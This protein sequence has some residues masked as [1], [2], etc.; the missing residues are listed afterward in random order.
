MDSILSWIGGKRL[1]RKQIIPMIPGD[2]IAYIEP[3]GGA[4]WILFAKERHAQVEV[5]NDLDGELVNLFMIIKYH[6]DALVQELAYLI[7][8]RALFVKVKNNPGFT[9]IQRAVRFLY[10]IK[11]SFGAKGAHYGTSKVSGGAGLAS[12]ANIIT[13]AEKLHSRLDKVAIE[14]KDFEAIVKSYDA[15]TS[16]FYF[17]PPYFRGNHF[18][19]RVGKFDHG[20]L[21]AVLPGMRG[22]WIVSIDDCVQAREMFGQWKIKTVTRKLGIRNTAA[23]SRDFKELLV[24]NF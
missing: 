6:L 11:R 20:R 9:D 12:H 13:L 5:Y 24:K 2:I 17:D 10:L 14:N 18:Y 7:S 3:F 4:G 8:S 19:P 16:F 15:A 22:R 21:A 23:G 1:L